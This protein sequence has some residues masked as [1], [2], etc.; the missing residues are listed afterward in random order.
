M[1]IKIGAA[2]IDGNFPDESVNTPVETIDTSE[3]TIIIERKTKEKGFEQTIS[4]GLAQ[5]TAYA[6]LRGYIVGKTIVAVSFIDAELTDTKFV[7]NARVVGCELS[8]MDQGAVNMF[9]LSK[10]N[11][12]EESQES[13]YAGAIRIV[14][15]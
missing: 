8:P 11:L 4:V 7:C 10:L 6:V 12:R 5:E 1:L 13:L 14:V 15:I 2:I 9:D 3:G